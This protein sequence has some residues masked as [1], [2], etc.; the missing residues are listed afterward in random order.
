MSTT[1]PARPRPQH[2]A[3][4]LLAAYLPGS[5]FYSSAR[6]ALLADGVHAAGRAPAPG[7]ARRGGGRGP[8][9]RRG[10]RAARA[11]GGRGARLRTRDPGRAWSCRR[12]CGAPARSTPA[13]TAAPTGSAVPA[14][15]APGRRP[16]GR[17][18]AARSPRTTSAACARAL[19]LIGG[20]ALSKVVLARSLE[21]DRAAPGAG[22]RAAGPAGARRPDRARVRRR[23]HRPRRPR[24]PHAG[25]RQPRAAGLPARRPGH[26]DPAGRLGPALRRPGGGPPAHRGAA[27]LGQGPPRARPGGGPGGA[28]RWAGSAPSVEVPA[29]PEVVGT[30]AMWHLSS[31]VTGRLVDPAVS[32]LAL[33]EA[34]HPTPAVC[35]VPTGRGPR[36]DRRHRAVRP[37]LLHRPGRLDRRSPA[38]ASGSS[39]SAA[40]RSCGRDGARCSPAPG[41]WRGS[42]AGRRAGRDQREVPHPAARDRDGGP[43]G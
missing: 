38:T 9:R 18:P 4:D 40:R 14:Q 16:A 27:R 2:R 12:S 33:A 23:R 6:G 20:G 34:L 31:R 37:R 19:E 35:G 10:G 22:A 17:W 26:R 1:A 43:R 24:H 15:R 7:V 32:A 8:G 29:E 13:A 39:R 11:G 28:R 5:F 3:A 41:S 36:R 25:R 21:V 42:R 30:A